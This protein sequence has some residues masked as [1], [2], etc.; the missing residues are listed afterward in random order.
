MLTMTFLGLEA[1]TDLPKVPYAT[2]LDNF[3]FIS[4][5]FIFATIVQVRIHTGWSRQIRICVYADFFQH[6]VST[7]TILWDVMF[8]TKN[9]KKQGIFHLLKC[10]AN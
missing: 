9:S 10:K 8:L 5:G 3:V 1:R 7:W 6:F 4:F 2:A